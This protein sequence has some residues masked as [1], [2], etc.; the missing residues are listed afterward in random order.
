VNGISDYGIRAVLEARV[1]PVLFCQELPWIVCGADLAA[2]AYGF[3]TPQFEVIYALPIVFH[4]LCSH[5]IAVLILQLT[6]ERCL[7]LLRNG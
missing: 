5:H 7:N 4:G 3:Q 2:A 1:L 6:A